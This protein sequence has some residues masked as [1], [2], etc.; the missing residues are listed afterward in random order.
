MEKRKTNRT[1]Y[2][3]PV[4]I[5]INDKVYTGKSKDISAGGMFIISPA[6]VN[7]DD[8]VLLIFD[9]PSISEAEITAFVRWRKSIG[10]G[11]QFASLRAQQIHSIHEI[12]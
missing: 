10:F 11:V 5:I 7:I 1:P 3:V 6:D 4:Q 8:E 9:L 12:K 2:Q